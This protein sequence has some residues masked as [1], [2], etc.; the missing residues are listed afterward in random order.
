MCV[1]VCVNFICQK[2]SVYLKTIR[3]VHCNLNAHW[4]YFPCQR[5]GVHMA[6]LILSGGLSRPELRICRMLSSQS[7]PLGKRL[8]E[9]E[10]CGTYKF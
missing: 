9:P 10:S 4:N 8:H 5:L 6:M 3:K 7:R 1:C 2:A